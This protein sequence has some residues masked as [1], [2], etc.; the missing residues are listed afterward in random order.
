MSERQVPSGA[1]PESTTLHRCSRANRSPSKVDIYAAYVGPVHG[2]DNA[3]HATNVGGKC[4]K[5]DAPSGFA[6]VR[7]R[8][9]SMDKNQTTKVCVPVDKNG[10]RREGVAEMTD[11]DPVVCKLEDFKP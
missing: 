8:T 5:G 1:D 7:A 2:L 6:Q 11:T 10:N 3:V 4:G 9:Y